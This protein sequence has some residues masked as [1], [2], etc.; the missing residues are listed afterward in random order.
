MNCLPL[1]ER[2]LHLG[3]RRRYGTYKARAFGAITVMVAAF[4]VLFVW[5]AWHPTANSGRAFLHLLA[6][7]G[8]FSA[9]LTGVLLTS[10]S[11]SRERRDGTLDLLLL[12][13]LRIG[14]VVVGK[15]LA[16]MVL[17]LC[18]FIATISRVAVLSH[19]RRHLLE[20]RR[21]A[22]AAGEQWV[23]CHPT[24]SFRTGSTGRVLA[25]P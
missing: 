17:P 10:D 8:Y 24:L 7:L 5:S 18:G 21:W 2:E 6:A 12:T 3:L 19:A 11:I 1:I 14:D 9:L 25:R 22:N 20:A 16:S 15:L 13:D 4:W 23:P